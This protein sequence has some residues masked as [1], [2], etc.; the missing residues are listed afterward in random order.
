MLGRRLGIALSNTLFSNSSLINQNAI[1]RFSTDAG[2]CD[3]V[4]LDCIECDFLYLGYIHRVD[5]SALF[6]LLCSHYSLSVK[7][8]WHVLILQRLK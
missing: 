5:S 8:L 2:R 1:S 3:Q 6:P 4:L 7:R